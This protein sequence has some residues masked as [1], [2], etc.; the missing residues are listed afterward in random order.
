MLNKQGC[1]DNGQ[2]DGGL[3]H[4]SALA[5]NRLLT[6]L[7]YKYF[8]IKHSNQPPGPVHNRGQEVRRRQEGGVIAADE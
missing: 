7:D 6:P 3:K 4:I 1:L 2:P 8:A 5:Q